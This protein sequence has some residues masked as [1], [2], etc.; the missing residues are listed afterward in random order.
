MSSTIV[1]R[2]LSTDQ[3]RLAAHFQRLDRH[4]LHARFGAGISPYRASLYAD[5]VFTAEALVYGAFPDG[6]LRAVAELRPLPNAWPKRAEAAFSVEPRW[7]G[8][9]I[10]DRL[11]HRVLTVAQ[12]RGI[13]ELHLLCLP[14]NLRMQ[15]L[16]Q[17]HRAR[18]H[19]LPGQVEAHLTR[20]F[21]TPFSITQEMAGE[22]RALADAMFQWRR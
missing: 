13:R 22:Y 10:G 4:S 19:R 1:R 20:P 16:A 9:G 11:M 17:K 14:G 3:R 6:C 7:Q 15:N 2:L 5:S 8:R 21:P 12:N 18:L